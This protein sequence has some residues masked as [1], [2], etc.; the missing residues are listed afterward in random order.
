MAS[1]VFISH[2]RVEYPA[3]AAAEAAKSYLELTST[4]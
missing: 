2:C 3:A 4:R 1:A